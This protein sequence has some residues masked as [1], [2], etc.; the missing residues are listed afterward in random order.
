MN[1]FSLS[2]AFNP[3]VSPQRHRLQATPS[4]LWCPLETSRLLFALILF[5]LPFI[6]VHHLQ[7]PKKTITTPF[8]LFGCFLFAFLFR[9][10]RLGFVCC[11]LQ[12]S[13]ST[14]S[15]QLGFTDVSFRF[16]IPYS[17]LIIERVMQVS[18]CSFP[19]P[20]FLN[21]LSGGLRSSDL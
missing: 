5:A 15:H 1:R 16:L 2:E 13:Y 12:G 6:G 4:C 14:G 9:T 7:G 21:L 8:W 10:F 18:P 11:R 17:A 19:V 20:G 3:V